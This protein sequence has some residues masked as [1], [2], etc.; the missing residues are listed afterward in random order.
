[1]I[2]VWPISF[3]IMAKCT[4]NEYCILTEL[5]IKIKDKPTLFQISQKRVLQNYF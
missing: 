5:M 2:I 4:E 1:M 3:V